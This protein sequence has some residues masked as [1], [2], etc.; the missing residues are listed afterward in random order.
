MANGA[1][2]AILKD[3]SANLKDATPQFKIDAHG[4]LGIDHF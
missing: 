2:S 4:A 1:A 3:L